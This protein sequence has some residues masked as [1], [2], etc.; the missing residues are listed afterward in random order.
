[1]IG[2]LVFDIIKQKNIKKIKSA[3]LSAKSKSLFCISHKSKVLI[4]KSAE[5]NIKDG[6][7]FNTPWSGRQ[8]QPASLSLGK[9]SEL[10]IGYFRTYS[11]THISVAPNAKLSL[12]SG[13]LNNNSKI[14]CFN[15]ITIGEDVKISEDVIIRD[16][17]NHTVIRKGYKMSAPIHIGNHVWV[18]VRA[19]I[20]KG[21]TIGDG[22]IIA[23][24]SVVT[25]D[26][27]ANTLV[28]GVP[29]KIIK[30]NISWE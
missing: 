15:E 3:L 7:F 11:G 12:G 20:L 30:D 17:D 6:F 5:V 19:I 18:G 22:A 27:P 26:V 2:T 14:N 28:G 1:M 29:A 16:S 9:N 13:F 21:V 10:N 25:R 8:N 4:D 23:A 24:G